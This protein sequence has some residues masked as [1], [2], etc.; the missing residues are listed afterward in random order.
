M[1]SSAHHRHQLS[2][3]SILPVFSLLVA[4][5]LVRLLFGISV[6]C[7]NRT[8]VD[9]AQG[10]SQDI[11]TPLLNVACA[12]TRNTWHGSKFKQLDTASSHVG[13]KSLDTPVSNKEAWRTRGLPKFK[14]H[15]VS[16]KLSK[17]RKRWPVRRS[18]NSG[19][20]QPNHHAMQAGHGV[21]QSNKKWWEHQWSQA[22][23]KD[24]SAC[25]LFI[26]SESFIDTPLGRRDGA[27]ELHGILVPWIPA[28]V[29]LFRF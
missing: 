7:W 19:H 26:F 22:R 3:S 20:E 8:R 1:I 13:Y 21:L 24:F 29:S 10:G 23:A 12:S 6:P 17:W 28:D 18:P 14:H 25:Q 15:C 4:G 16:L 11:L 27:C 9:F 2:H 5:T